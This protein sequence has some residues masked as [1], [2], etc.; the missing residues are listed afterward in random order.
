MIPFIYCKK[1]VYNQYSKND[2]D[3][4]QCVDFTKRF[5]KNEQ[6]FLKI[7]HKRSFVYGKNN[8]YDIVDKLFHISGCNA[9]CNHM[10]AINIEA[11]IIY[12]PTHVYLY[13]KML[14]NSCI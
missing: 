11:V 6:M 9:M 7:S 13:S 8:P 2:T 10:L 4:I 3:C 5:F 14:R 1:N 12:F